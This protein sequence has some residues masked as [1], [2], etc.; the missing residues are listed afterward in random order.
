MDV[1]RGQDEDYVC[2]LKRGFCCFWMLLWNN[3]HLL[4][5]KEEGKEE[6]ILNM[7]IHNVIHNAIRHTQSYGYTISYGIHKATCHTQ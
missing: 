1:E 4:K 5:E 3:T 2:Q 7:A 6:E